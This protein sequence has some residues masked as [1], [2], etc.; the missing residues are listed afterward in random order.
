[1]S[2]LKQWTT[3]QTCHRI[4]RWM[5]AL[6]G[7]PICIEC[8][9]TARFGRESRR[10]KKRGYHDVSRAQIDLCGRVHVECSCSLTAPSLVLFADHPVSG[11]V[12]R[13]CVTFTRWTVDAEGMA[14]GVETT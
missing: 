8:L 2:D 9:S 3:C 10:C 7:K 5:D 11:W 14:V 13:A 1:M 4:D 12:D 6:D